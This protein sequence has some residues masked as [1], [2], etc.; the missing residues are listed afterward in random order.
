MASDHEPANHWSKLASDLGAEVP[1]DAS[2]SD[3]SAS[4]ETPETEDAAARPALPSKP[5]RPSEPRP[6]TNWRDLASDLGVESSQEEESVLHE[7]TFTP[8][9]DNEQHGAVAESG[10]FGTDDCVDAKS[11]FDDHGSNA[12]IERPV[13]EI[14]DVHGTECDSALSSDSSPSSDQEAV[15]KYV[16]TQAFGDEAR[17][18]PPR[19]NDDNATARST[20]GVPA[21]EHAFDLS[22]FDNEGADDMSQGVDKEEQ[23]SEQRPRKRRRGRRGRRQGR[24]QETERAGEPSE[25]KTEGAKE[26]QDNSRETDRDE[27]S[28]EEGGRPRRSRRRRRRRGPKPTPEAAI[29]T[30][31]AGDVE[32]VDDV[33][34]VGDTFDELIGE[35]DLVASE[36][37]DEIDADASSSDD[38]SENRRVGHRK[39]PSWQEAVETVVSANLAMRAKSTRQVRGEPRGRGRG[40]GGGHGPRS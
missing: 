25:K 11:T 27:T 9:G 24:V 35:Q 20:R 19:E 16:Q 5:R 7:N 13:P 21:E 30:D 23:P 2:I 29:S 39:I 17:P 26:Q 36:A 18:V 6:K 14:V 3:M 37:I 15:T 1:A 8:L 38:E 22:I 34:D 4:T 31:D 28:E 33:D 32:D 40:R 10:G 12:V